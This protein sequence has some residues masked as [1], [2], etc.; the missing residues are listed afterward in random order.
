MVETK[1]TEQLDADDLESA[2]TALKNAVFHL[3]S[4]WDALGELEGILG[5]EVETDEISGITSNV[6]SDPAEAFQLDAEEL[7][8]FLNSIE[9]EEDEEEDD[10]SEEGN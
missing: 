6:G 5:G 9:S 8:E 2:R 3:A 7:D 10:D 4:C 1:R